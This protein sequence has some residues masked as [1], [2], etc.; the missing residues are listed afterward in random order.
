MS[1]FLLTFFLIYGGVHLYLFAK[2]RAAFHPGVAGSIVIIVVLIL[3]TLAPILVRMFERYGHGTAA[4]ITA[5]MGYLWMGLLFIFFVTSLLFDLY[6]LLIHTGALMFRKDLSGLAL[7]PLYAF[8]LPLVI[9]AGINIY[10]YFEAKNIRTE[11]ITIA[12]SKIPEEAG[13]IRIVQISDVH[14]GIIVTGERLRHIV[15]EV[16]KTDP[17]IFVSTGDL[18][19]GQ[20]DSLDEHT[21]LLRDVKARYGKFAITG[22]H[23]FYAGLSQ[24]LDF[25][26]RA[27]FTVL[28]GEGLNVA[29]MI[30]IAGVDDPTVEAYDPSRAVPEKDL[31]S[32][33]SGKHFTVLLK[34]RPA[35][36]D[37]SVG[38][39]DLQLSGHTHNGQIFPFRFVTRLFYPLRSGYFN[40]PTHDYV[41]VN[42]GTGTWGP[43]IRFLAPPEITVIDLIHEKIK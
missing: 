34:H 28:R 38:L 21:S 13:R 15:E 1:L 41:H 23:E 27:G 31:L 3:M 32:H 2:I 5:Y 6:H 9:S 17:D 19:D 26:R 11:N 29:G 43:P 42:R 7:S 18:V 35:I 4:G 20:I 30:N 39:F 37:G 8:L 33:F 25:T 36:D 40:P 12:S 22:N 14:I 10:G 16:K 24:A